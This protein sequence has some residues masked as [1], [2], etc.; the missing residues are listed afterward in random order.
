VLIDGVL[1]QFDTPEAVYRR[2]RSV[3]VASFIGL[4]NLIPGR[5]T[6]RAG[7]RL[8]VQTSV[9]PLRARGPLALKDGMDAVLSIRPENLEL[10]RRDLPLPG[11]GVNHLRGIVR[12]RTYLGSLYDYRVDVGE[13]TRLR[14]QGGVNAVHQ[15]ADE[16]MVSF[17]A[18][19]GW[20][21]PV[22]PAPGEG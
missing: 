20:A 2:P 22:F 8:V 21:L 1:Q 13:D 18:A 4:T 10:D 19:A 14:V 5:V 11:D 15:V 7:D 12:E 3:R 17:D 6:A 9:G 16:V